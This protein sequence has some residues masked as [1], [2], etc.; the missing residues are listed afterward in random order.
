MRIE[1][2][3]LL[4]L[5]VKDNLA[6]TEQ[7]CMLIQNRIQSAI[8]T[9]LSN[10]DFVSI[11]VFL[12]WEFLYYI[13]TQ[14]ISICWYFTFFREY[15]TLYLIIFLSIYKKLDVAILFQLFLYSLVLRQQFFI[16][17]GAFASEFLKKSRR[18][19]Y[20][21]FHNISQELIE[22]FKK[23]S[24]YIYKCNKILWIYIFSLIYLKFW[25]IS[26]T[27]MITFTTDMI[28]VLSACY[29]CGAHPKSK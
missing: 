8:H 3:S 14:K 18:N 23:T 25:S 7:L 9:Y 12:S 19:E 1:V 4:C 29:L 16:N 21:L 15:F 10:T 5:L 20:T 17:S 28:S 11:G 2:R 6:A 13:C 24:L 22:L 26:F 27:K